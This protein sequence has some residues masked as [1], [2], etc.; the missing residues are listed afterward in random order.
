MPRDNS[1]AC[2]FSFLVI[3]IIGMF[4]VAAYQ[5]SFSPEAKIKNEVM[6]LR[7]QKEMI[8]WKKEKVNL[9]RY[10]EQERKKVENE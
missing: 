3:I 4:V 10:L 1:G 8:L 7:K 5:T 9:Q 2:I 6:K